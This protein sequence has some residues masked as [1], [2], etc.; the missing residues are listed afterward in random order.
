M[1]T[2]E[3]VLVTGMGAVAPNGNDVETIWASVLEGRSG[4]DHIVGVD[5]SELSVKIGGQVR[6]LDV[7]RYLTVAEQR[8]LDP[9]SIYGIAAAA[10]AMSTVLDEEGKHPFDPRR[11]SV[12]AATGYGPTQIV[13]KGTRALDERG[14]RSVSPYSVVYGA[15]DAASS[16]LSVRYH[17][18]AASHALS[19]ACASGSVGVGE[20]MRTIRHGYADAVLVVG[21]EDS[22]NTQDLAGTANI[23]ALASDHN[24]TPTKASRPFDRSRSGFVMSCGGASVLLESESSATR[25]GARVLGEVIGYGSSSDAH[26]ATA[27]HPEGLGARNSMTDALVDAGIR[28]D[29]IDYVNAHGTGT[30]YNDSTELAAISAVFG[31]FAT[32]IPISS[33]KSSTGH[34]IGAAGVLEA[35]FCLLVIR[36]GVVPPTIN[37]DDPEF[38]EFDLVPHNARACS[39]ETAMSNS[40]GFGGHN[41]TVIF[42]S[43]TGA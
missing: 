28:V 31:D 21:S 2:H 38:P 35:I 18:Q 11:F 5:V 43:G 19:A 32:R 12:L 16:F 15:A 26:H 7:N 25:R 39:V 34:L 23:R 10:E 33:T 9:S 27:P 24:N 42:S 41:A 37:L 29:A 40:F 4:I 36:D 30:A 13:H 8:R 20:A 17:A 6:G 1:A 22:V 14:A 3:R